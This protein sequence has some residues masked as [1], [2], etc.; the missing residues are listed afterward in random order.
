MIQIALTITCMAQN[1]TIETSAKYN[2]KVPRILWENLEAVLLTQSKKYI[3]ELAKILGVPAKELQKRVMP[4]ANSVKVILQ[5]TQESTCRAYVQ[6]GAFT[7]FCR[8]PVFNGDFCAAHCGVRPIVNDTN[9]APIKK[10]KDMDMLP[11]MWEKDTSIP[12]I[13]DLYVASGQRIGK[14]NHDKQKITI[15]TI[16]T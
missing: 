2:Y 15:Y 9:A 11:P 4:S 3:E 7:V 13:S 8:K 10:V 12:A 16:D 14:V 1:N 6:N 5:D